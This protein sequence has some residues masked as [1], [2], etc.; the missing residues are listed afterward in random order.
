M[1]WHKTERGLNNCASN[2]PC[3]KCRASKTDFSKIDSSFKNK[4]DAENKIRSLEQSNEYLKKKKK[5]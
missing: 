2:F 4:T 5:K 3:V 1:V